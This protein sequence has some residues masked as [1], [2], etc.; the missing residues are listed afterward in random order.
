MIKINQNILEV[1]TM[2]KT[3]NNRKDNSDI[4][5]ENFKKLIATAKSAKD[6]AIICCLFET[7]PRSPELSKVRLTRKDYVS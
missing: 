3:K 5:G 2:N 4:T 1:E 6:K 7:G